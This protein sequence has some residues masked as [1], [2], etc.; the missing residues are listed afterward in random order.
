MNENPFSLD[1]VRF[2]QEVLADILSN[3]H[4][5]NVDQLIREAEQVLENIRNRMFD[6]NMIA[7]ED[8]FI[9][10]RESMNPTE[11]YPL[12]T[13]MKYN[14]FINVIKQIYLKEDKLTSD[15]SF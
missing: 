7:I 4:G 3:I 5:Q 12:K 15:C 10:A 9:S 8:E 2:A 1:A 11:Y 6:D 14:S 13:N